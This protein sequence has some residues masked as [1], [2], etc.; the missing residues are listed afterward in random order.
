[1]G[2]TAA[3][4]LNVGGSLFDTQGGSTVVDTSLSTLGLTRNNPVVRVTSK[5][6]PSS[7]GLQAP[8]LNAWNLQVDCVPAE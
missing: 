4:A 8:T 2:A 3:A 7:D 5:L 6:K 1:M